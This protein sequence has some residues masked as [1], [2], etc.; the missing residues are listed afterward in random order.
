MASSAS[1]DLCCVWSGLNESV[2]PV[3]TF[4]VGGC[5]LNLHRCHKTMIDS[6]DKIKKGKVIPTFLRVTGTEG[7]W[8]N[9]GGQPAN[10]DPKAILRS[11]KKHWQNTKQLFLLSQWLSRWLTVFFT[12]RQ[13][14]VHCQK[15]SIFQ[16]ACPTE[17]NMVYYFYDLPL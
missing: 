10:V 12:I 3:V 9:A 4:V 7:V 8:W 17:G 13:M 6:Q 15:T 11:F 1:C 14:I 5:F 16:E 2:R